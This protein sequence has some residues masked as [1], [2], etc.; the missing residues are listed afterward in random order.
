[1]YFYGA[2]LQT[3]VF[4]IKGAKLKLNVYSS[5]NNCAF[6]YGAVATDVLVVGGSDGCLYVGV[7]EEAVG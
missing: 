5:L 7:V 3:V 6:T 2:L 1:M 4:S